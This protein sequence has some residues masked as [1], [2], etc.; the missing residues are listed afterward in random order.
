MQGWCSLEDVERLKYLMEK[1]G[2]LR[3]VLAPRELLRGH[4]RAIQQRLR[5]QSKKGLLQTAED[6]KA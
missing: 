2:L 6:V 3:R 5:Q 4:E 1:V